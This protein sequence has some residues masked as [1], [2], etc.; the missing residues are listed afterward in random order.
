MNIRWDDLAVTAEQM[1]EIDDK[2]IE[3]YGVQLI[4]MMENAGLHLAE[5]ARRLLSGVV[6][7]KSI[8]V[9]C[10]PGNNGGGGMVAARHLQNW[11][12]SV[13]VVL[14]ASASRLMPVPAQQWKTV[15]ALGLVVESPAVTAELIIDALLGY[16]GTGNPRPPIDKW[17]SFANDSGRPILSLDIPSGLNATTGAAGSPCIRATA[18][19]TLAL[20]KTGLLQ[21]HAEPYV[22]D[23]YLA[24]I[25]IPQQAYKDLFP[26]LELSNPF[27]E[28][29]IIG[30]KS[31]RNKGE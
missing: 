31:E 9:L 26:N 30:L 11:G 1:R 24:D 16:S 12:A 5:L 29:E 22:G 3:T 27:H 19:L 13:Q 7:D 10:G 6:N 2:A 8:L 4:Q 17:I 28:A 15:S 20:P 18:T 25:G 21:N 14:A 23:L